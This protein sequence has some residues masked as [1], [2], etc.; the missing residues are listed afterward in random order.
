MTFFFYLPVF[1]KFR[2]N[3]NGKIQFSTWQ[4]KT[5]QHCLCNAMQK[6][7]FHVHAL[8]ISL[9]KAAIIFLSNPKKIFKMQ[10][11]IR[12]WW[13]WDDICSISIFFHW[14]VQFQFWFHYYPFSFL[15]NWYKVRKNVW[16]N[17][18][19]INKRIKL[20]NKWTFHFQWKVGA[21]ATGVPTTLTPDRSA[22]DVKMAGVK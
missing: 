4:S 2:K 11:N 5:S 20:K 7:I 17:V 9:H 1:L 16:S 12:W 15:R 10:R 6:P 22:Q 18:V 8:S 14:I 13:W 21:A 3:W 19:V